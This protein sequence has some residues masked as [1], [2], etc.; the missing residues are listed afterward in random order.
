MTTTSEK[1][2]TAKA[3][4]RRAAD[5]SNNELSGAQWAQRFK[6]SKNTK[7][8][9]PAF[10]KAV[11]AFIDAMT[12]AGIKV[13]IS[14]TYRPIQRCYL[15]HWCWQIKY[16]YVKPENVPSITG[17]DINWVHPTSAASLEA[18]RQ[19]VCAFDMSDLNTAPAL[20]SLHN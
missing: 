1:L 8:L 12:E 14:A 18:A 10:R 17:V 15:M 4:T 11:D 7:D 13:R 2:R 5:Q 6:G 3:A 9:A 19:M 16:K 20:Y